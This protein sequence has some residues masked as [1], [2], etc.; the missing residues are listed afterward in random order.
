[1]KDSNLPHIDG[2]EAL[3]VAGYVDPA[4]L[5]DDDYVEAIAAMFADS[6]RFNLRPRPTILPAP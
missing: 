3:H 5:G 2:L 1:M 6:V 4:R